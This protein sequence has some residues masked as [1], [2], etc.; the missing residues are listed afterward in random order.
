MRTIVD[1]LG[2]MKKVDKLD[3]RLEH[4]FYNH[5]RGDLFECTEEDRER[6]PDETDVE[7][8]L[9]VGDENPGELIRLDNSVLYLGA[10]IED[11]ERLCKETG[12]EV[13]DSQSIDESVGLNLGRRRVNAKQRYFTHSEAPESILL[14]TFHSIDN[15]YSLRHKVVAGT[16]TLSEKEMFEEVD[17]KEADIIVRASLWINGGAIRNY[18]T[19]RQPSLRIVEAARK[20]RE[21]PASYG[22]DSVSE[23]GTKSLM[24]LVGPLLQTVVD[25]NVPA[26]L[27]Y[28]QRTYT[29]ANLP[30]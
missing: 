10:T 23:Q 13:R 11:I 9:Y 3:P 19:Q 2:W 29:V 21:I 20:A 30:Q 5:A 8:E 1:Y 28:K 14:R 27:S 25:Q 18:D 24:M 7:K 16:R 26:V 22:L 17:E 4:L 12:F 15:P 6:F